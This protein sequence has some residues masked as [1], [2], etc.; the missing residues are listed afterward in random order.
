MVGNKEVAMK[1]YQ[2]AKF[3][4]DTQ[5]TYQSYCYEFCGLLNLQFK[6]VKFFMSSREISL[7]RSVRR[8]CEIDVFHDFGSSKFEINSLKPAFNELLEKG[9]FSD[10]DIVVNG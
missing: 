8:P 1:K 7:Q 4:F 5:R 9:M 3:I 2:K 6:D 10:L